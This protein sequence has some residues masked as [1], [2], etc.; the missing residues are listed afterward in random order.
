MFLLN[1]VKKLAVR[2]AACCDVRL[3]ASP[4][5]DAALQGDSTAS[6]VP[7]ALF[8]GVVSETVCC[9]RGTGDDG[10]M[11]IATGNPARGAFG[12]TL[13]ST[14]LSTAGIVGTD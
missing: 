13:S 10:V 2:V 1:L 11:P 4:V 9:A 5:F 6:G 14:S 7:D 12:L 3:R 8:I